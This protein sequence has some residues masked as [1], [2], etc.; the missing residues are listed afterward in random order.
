MSLDLLAEEKAHAKYSA[1]GSKRWLKCHG[2]TALIEKAPEPRESKYAKEGTTAHSV[3]EYLGKNRKK[4]AQAAAFLRKSYP[5]DM[6][7][8]AEAALDY[9]EK[10]L[11]KYSGADLEI[12]VRCDL[13]VTEKDQ[14]GTTDLA[15]VELYGRLI[16]I[17][18]KYGAGVP[19]FPDENSQL[20]YYALALA[21]KY[22]YCFSEVELVVIQPRRPIPVEGKPPGAIE[23][24]VRSW[25]TSIETLL[26]WRDKFEN[27]IVANKKAAKNPEAHLLSG[28]HCQFCPAAVICPE[29][30]NKALRKAQATFDDDLSELSLPVVSSRRDLTPKMIADFLDAAETLEIW[31]KAVRD[32]AE[33]IIENGVQIPGWGF[34]DKRGS[35]KYTN[36]ER[37][38]KEARKYFGDKAYSK[39]ELLSPAQIEKACAS[40]PGLLAKFM[41]DH[42]ATVSSGVTLGRIKAAEVFNDKEVSDAVKTG[43]CRKSRKRNHG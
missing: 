26:E 35:R 2:S 42:V 11:K 18:Y 10:R 6:V 37:A 43:N 28:D 40:K 19:V 3:L 8:Y 41:K 27:G 17:D 16:V 5:T 15:I 24:T 4:R 1:S 29:I 38:D 30:K 36:I 7:A 33:G 20:I 9:V 23:E 12:E 21:H 32:F 25:T 31:T 13:P 14:F 34:V 39:P 22:D